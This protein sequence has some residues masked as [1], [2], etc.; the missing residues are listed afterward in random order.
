MIG[1]TKPRRLGVEGNMMA[2]LRMFAHDASGIPTLTSVT[3]IELIYGGEGYPP[4]SST[5]VVSG[6]AG[7]G[8][9]VDIEVDADG[10]VTSAEINAVGS[11]YSYEQPDETLTIDGNLPGEPDATLLI[12]TA[13]PGTEQRGCC[14]YIGVARNMTVV[15]ESGTPITFSGL[16]PGLYPIQ[17]T[18]ILAESSGGIGD[19][20]AIY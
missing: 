5:R 3:S 14:F 18:H 1:K 6:G 9:T 10:I 12:S 19:I 13:I 20:I 4:G 8:L 7:I 2:E 17:I 11:G 16:Q 15:M